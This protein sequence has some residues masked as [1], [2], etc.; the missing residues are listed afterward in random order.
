MI[1]ALNSIEYFG[2]NDLINKIEWLS[3]KIAGV[4][5]IFHI[6]TE[7]YNY[8]FDPKK[9]KIL[10]KNLVYLP[11]WIISVEAESVYKGIFERITP[12][13]V[14]E[15]T[16][17]KKYDWLVIGRRRA[18]FPTREY[19][20]P[21]DGKISYDFRKIEG[22]AKVLNSEMEKREA[23]ELTRQQIESHHQFFG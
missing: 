13:I 4:L 11:F 20:V 21:L 12:P 16:I 23:L 9:S 15:G 19:D 14:K 18:N 7:D 5:A 10:E 8:N 2:N 6:F 1:N 17:E 3:Y 22:F